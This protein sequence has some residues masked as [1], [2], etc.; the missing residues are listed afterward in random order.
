MTRAGIPLSVVVITCDRPEW[1]R[2]MLDSLRGQVSGRDEVLLIDDGREPVAAQPMGVSHL[3]RSAGYGAA[4]ARNA[5]LR[6][7]GNEWI[8]FLDDDVV[9]P[10]N[11]LAEVRR[12]LRSDELDVLTANVLCHE[13]CGATGD[14]FDERYSL[15][16]GPGVSTYHGGTGT[17]SSPND[18]WRVGVG[19]V[20]AWRTTVLRRIGGFPEDLGQGRRYGGAEDLAAF[21]AA[22]NA[23]AIIRYD[24]SLL[25]RHRSPTTMAEFVAKMRGYALADG[26]LAS[27]VWLTERDSGMIRHLVRDITR[28]PL[29]FLA[30]SCRAL[31]GRTHLPLAPIAAFPWWA[32]RGLLGYRKSL[33]PPRRCLYESDRGYS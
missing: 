25:V 31:V 29:T 16:R 13:S 28:A 20:M 33:Q 1:C 19:A 22:L 14:L 7:A 32:S 4:A 18:I 9:I 27:H 12:R 26:A 10:H 30:E 5:G 17:P 3:I 23:G 8:L 11:F 21:R 15:S 2:A 24:G 6:L